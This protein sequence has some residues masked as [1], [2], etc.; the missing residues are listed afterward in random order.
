MYARPFTGIV[1]S[2]LCGLAFSMTPSRGG[3]ALVVHTLYHGGEKTP[4]RVIPV[5]PL[6][7]PSAFP[8]GAWEKTMRQIDPSP[9]EFLFLSYF[10]SVISPQWFQWPDDATRPRDAY[11]AACRYVRNTPESAPFDG[12]YWEVED[13]Q[14]KWVVRTDISRQAAADIMMYSDLF[15]REFA[16]FLTPWG[17]VKN[18]DTPEAAASFELTIHVF[19]KKASY[20]R[21]CPQENQAAQISF[22]GEK[23]KFDLF[24]LWEGGKEDADL[25]YRGTWC[26]RL[27]YALIQAVFLHAN[28]YGDLEFFSTPLARTF[29]STSFIANPRI[30]EEIKKD[31]T[32]WTIMIFSHPKTPL[33]PPSVASLLDRKQEKNSSLNLRTLFLTWTLF[34]HGQ[35]FTMDDVFRYSDELTKP[36][37]LWIKMLLNQQQ[38]RERI[39]QKWSAFWTENTER[40][41]EEKSRRIPPDDPLWT[42]MEQLA[43][44]TGNKAWGE[45]REKYRTASA[46]LYETLLLLEGLGDVESPGM[47]EASPTDGA[48]G[49]NSPTVENSLVWKMALVAHETGKPGAS[50]HTAAFQVEDPGDHLYFHVRRK[51]AEMRRAFL[52]KNNPEAL[53]KGMDIF[54][55]VDDRFPAA[56]REWY[57]NYSVLRIPFPGGYAQAAKTA[58]ERIA[59][60][61]TE[62]KETV[63][64]ADVEL[65]AD[66]GD[67]LPH[68]LKQLGYELRVD[69]PPYAPQP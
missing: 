36:S 63:F 3:E 62:G 40:F 26:D 51:V 31:F 60:H 39:Q 41:A 54:F 47:E 58:T 34:N 5:P 4:V 7:V 25:R 17:L 16:K 20:A 9:S 28:P 29:E 18:Q 67:S 37:T 8:R 66:Y 27:Q 65:F 1:L 69:A 10:P 35:D 19:S 64:V 53:K 52:L 46:S 59:A 57:E 38:N 22:N 13:P 21:Q 50:L 42:D 6:F 49:G 44:E 33:D 32:Y 2:A 43:Q 15:T 45:Y 61:H 56:L 23:D 68:Q 24:L 14:K 55:A 30:R 11:F 48:K 12:D